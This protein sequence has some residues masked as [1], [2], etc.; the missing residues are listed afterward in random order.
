MIDGDVRH[1]THTQLQLLQDRKCLEGLCI[2]IH[3][4]KAVHR[5]GSPE[6]LPIGSAESD[7][8]MRTRLSNAVKSSALYCR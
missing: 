8:F 5:G 4:V 1:S 6:G 2:K 7:A 3:S